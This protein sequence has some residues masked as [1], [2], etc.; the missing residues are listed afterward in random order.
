MIQFATNDRGEA[1]EILPMRYQRSS[2][3]IYTSCD[4]EEKEKQRAIAQ[5]KNKKKSEK[6]S[7][8]QLKLKSQRVLMVLTLGKAGAMLS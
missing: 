3:L 5:E 6:H 7:K 2:I 1:A 8:F 4:L